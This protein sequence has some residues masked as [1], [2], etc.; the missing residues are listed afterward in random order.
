MEDWPLKSLIVFSRNI[1]LKPVS[2]YL[3]LVLPARLHQ[4]TSKI[5]TLREHQLK[6]VLPTVVQEH[7]GSPVSGR[8]S[9]KHHDTS[10]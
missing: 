2:Y 9:I 3:L 4:T 7:A 10:L 1:Y 8:P 5:G 6:K